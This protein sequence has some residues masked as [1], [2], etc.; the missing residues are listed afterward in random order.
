MFTKNS[1]KLINEPGNDSGYQDLKPYR[2]RRQ[3]DE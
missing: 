1:T 3:F 2:G